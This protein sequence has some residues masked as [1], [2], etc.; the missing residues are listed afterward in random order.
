[1]VWLDG[2]LFFLREV[3]FIIIYWRGDDND[4]YLIIVMYIYGY[5]FFIDIEVN[6][7]VWVDLLYKLSSWWISSYYGN[8]V[9]FVI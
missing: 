1:M 3:C 8:D 6:W 9:W 4:F 5:I 7:I 2:F